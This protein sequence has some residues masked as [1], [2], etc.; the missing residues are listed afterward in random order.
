MDEAE[1]GDESVAVDHLLFHPKILAAVTDQ[2]VHFLERAFVKQ[3]IDA[4][5][6]GEFAFF[7][8]TGAAFLATSRI[9]DGVPPAQLFETIRHKIV[10]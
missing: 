9:G 10:E 1:A 6:R 7:V 4:L 5:A 8:L 3:Q 2:L